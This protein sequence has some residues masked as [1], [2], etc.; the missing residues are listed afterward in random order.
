[1]A[2]LAITS[3]KGGVGKTTCAVNLCAAMRELGHD[4]ILLD[5]DSGGD[6]TWLLGFRSADIALDVLL[7]R[8]ELT[9]AVSSTGEGVRLLPASPRL[10]E[11]ETANVQQLAERF[12]YLAKR[13]LIVADLPPGF[14]PA[15]TRAAIMAATVI[16]VPLIPEPLAERRARHVLDTAEALGSTA[17][18]LAVATMADKRRSLTGAVLE[19]AQQGGLEVIGSVPRSVAVPECGNDGVSVLRYDSTS[20]A[21]TAY[22]ELT[23]RLLQELSLNSDKC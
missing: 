15:V 20:S 22:R 5:A 19:I 2:L 6:A 16:L 10:I 13:N 11:I 23:P 8:K 1:M 9:A 4:P 17:T 18:I 21:A 3:G 12:R 14:S 7:G